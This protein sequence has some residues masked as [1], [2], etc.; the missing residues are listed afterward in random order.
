MKKYVK[1][2]ECAIEYQEKFLI[3]ERPANVYA[4]G[5]LSFP[6]GKVDEVDENESYDIL[7]AAAKREV[8]EEVG[9]ELTEKLHYITSSCFEVKPENT[10]IASIFYCKI[11]DKAAAPEVVASER[12]VAS[13]S[14]MTPEDICAAPNSPQ[15]LKTYIKLV[16]QYKGEQYKNDN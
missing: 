1:I 6:A 5:L 7:R 15:W 14:W 2:V 8:L 4:G 10:V 16:E 9:I 3:I 13:Y 12:E 11:K